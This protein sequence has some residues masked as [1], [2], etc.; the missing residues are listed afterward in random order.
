[1]LFF[2][3][4][5]RNN[6]YAWTCYCLSNNMFRVKTH[7]MIKHKIQYLHRQGFHTTRRRSASL[8]IRRKDNVNE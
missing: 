5:K 2:L 6:D 3:K 8:H 4:L 7:R 1:M